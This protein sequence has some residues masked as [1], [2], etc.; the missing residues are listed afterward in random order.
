MRL[1][2]FWLVMFCFLLAGCREEGRDGAIMI[3][4]EELSEKE[5]EKWD[6]YDVYM[7]GRVTR[8]FSKTTLEKL[9]KLVA[10][11][12]R[13]SEEEFREV[14]RIEKAVEKRSANEEFRRIIGKL[15]LPLLGKRNMWKSL[16]EKG[17]LGFFV[18]SIPVIAQKRIHPP[19]LPRKVGDIVAVKGWI[20]ESKALRRVVG[21]PFIIVGWSVTPWEPPLTPPEPPVLLWPDTD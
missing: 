11:E 3:R 16:S 1:I 4:K 14:V 21:K 18:G 2:L 6:P 20:W 8:L 19:S 7:V 12:A 10:K 9:R 13:R 15:V 17:F 5:K